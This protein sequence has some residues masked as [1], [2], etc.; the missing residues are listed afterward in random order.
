M[1]LLLTGLEAGLILG[2]L[3]WAGQLVG[4]LKEV[5][6]YTVGCGRLDRAPPC[7]A[8]LLEWI[9]MVW[10]PPEAGRKLTPSPKSPINRIFD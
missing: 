9:N 2:G 5:R 10:F 1:G 6:L 3:M 4:G 7:W 8:R